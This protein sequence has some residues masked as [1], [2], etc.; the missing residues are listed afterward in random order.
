MEP[1]L[2]RDLRILVNRDEVGALL[3]A[4][5]ALSL[6]RLQPAAA[7][8]PLSIGDAEFHEAMQ[9]IVND[10]RLASHPPFGVVTDLL[11]IVFHRDEVEVVSSNTEWE[12]AGRYRLRLLLPWLRDDLSLEAT[13]LV[14]QNRRGVVRRRFLPFL[15]REIGRALH[16]LC[17]FPVR[18]EC[19]RLPPVAA[20]RRGPIEREALVLA[21][22]SVHALAAAWRDGGRLL[23]GEQVLLLT[24]VRDE[25]DVVPLREYHAV[26]SRLLPIN[27]KTVQ[28]ARNARYSHCEV[29]DLRSPSM[30]GYSGLRAGGNLEQ[31]SA[32]VPSEL[33][34][35]E[36]DMKPDTF[37]I[38]LLE[39]R[40]LFFERDQQIDIRRRRR[41]HVV[42]WAPSS[43]DYRPAVVP[44]RWQYLFL[45]V[46]FDIIRF[47]RDELSITNCP[48][49][50]VFHGEVEGVERYERL[51]AAIREQD[52]RDVDIACFVLEHGRLARHFE[53]LM[54][55]QDE[56][57]VLLCLAE[58]GTDIAADLPHGAA[59]VRVEFAVDSGVDS[60]VLENEG[61][62]QVFSITDESS[63]VAELNR[64]RN[65]LAITLAGARGQR[66][67]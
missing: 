33:A 1:A 66:R 58:R 7:R 44:A 60:V 30:G 52:F 13:S 57:Q 32:I 22:E 56:E 4:S 47:F 26:R 61:E 6:I 54:D 49:Y 3:E 41:F 36:T 55:R 51:I 48:F 35:M 8:D 31:L 18:I 2:K 45:G 25:A 11:K 43:F 16:D 38:N 37:D 9:S 46:V 24:Y 29:R 12:G 64:F 62:R 21:R 63:L 10:T 5:A 27:L 53:A 39:K 19:Q 17:R 15:A 50:F 59:N 14:A 20:L 28:R 40:L 23:T 42:F 65:T 34:Q 67:N